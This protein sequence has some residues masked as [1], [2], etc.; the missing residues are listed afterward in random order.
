MAMFRIYDI[1][2][3][4]NHSTVIPPTSPELFRDNFLIALMY[5]ITR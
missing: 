5:L 1:I 4:N 3:S 2:K